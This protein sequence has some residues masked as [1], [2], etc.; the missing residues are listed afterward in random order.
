MQTPPSSAPFLRSEKSDARN[1]NNLAASGTDPSVLCRRVFSAKLCHIHPL[2]DRKSMN[3][4]VRPDDLECCSALD[5]DSRK[6]TQKS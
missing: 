6:I 5:R 1:R 3:S 2:S 4:D